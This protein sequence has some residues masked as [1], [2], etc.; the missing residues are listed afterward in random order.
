MTGALL[1]YDQARRALQSATR[2]EDVKSIRDKSKALEA[3]AKAALDNDLQVW[4]GEIKLRA[5]R[6]LGELLVVMQKHPG[7]RPRK[8]GS[9]GEPV[10][11]LEQLGIERKFAM[12]VQRLAALPEKALEQY[13]EEC[14]LV[15]RPP[16][17]AALIGKGRTDAMAVHHSSA[18]GE[19]YTPADVVERVRATF[20]GRI[21]LDPCCNPGKPNVP[22]RSYYRKTDDGLRKPWRG[23]VYCNPPYDDALAWVTKAVQEHQ[24]GRTA[25]IVLL[26]AARTDTAW[27]RALRDF[28]VCFIH[29]RLTF[30]GNAAAAPFPSVLFWISETSADVFAATF[31]DI[32]TTYTRLGA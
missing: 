7:G 31:E 8:T 12:F 30:V 21:D 1:R 10:S 6:R 4:A 17:S 18:S 24:E 14:R 25:A 28:P 2:L 27:F 9:K 13:I 11:T 15:G 23:H 3:Y 5:E 19:H 16:R 22:A 20:G 26:L 29:G 32:G